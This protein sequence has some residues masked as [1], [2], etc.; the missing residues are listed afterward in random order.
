MC[1][2]C[3]DCTVD[4]RTTVDQK[5]W[6]EIVSWHSLANVPADSSLSDPV[7]TVTPEK[8]E[9]FGSRSSTIVWQKKSCKY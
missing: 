7:N 6:D 4:P 8:S 1:V 5:L 3:R 2:S 9:Q